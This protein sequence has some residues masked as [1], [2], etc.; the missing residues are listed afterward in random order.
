MSKIEIDLADLPE[1]HISEFGNGFTTA[2]A[3]EHYQPTLRRNPEDA[4]DGS[5][6]RKVAY[7]N[8]AI[9]LA[10]EKRESAEGKALTRRRDAAGRKCGVSGGSYADATHPERLL[11]DK[12]IEL[13]DSTN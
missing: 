9:A 12:I 7:A 11:I 13:E 3:Q 6:S 5:W 1:V 2:L 8:L 10:V 4:S